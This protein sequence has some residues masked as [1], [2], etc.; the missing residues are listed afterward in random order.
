MTVHNGG[1]FQPGFALN[2]VAP[3]EARDDDVVVDAGGFSVYVDPESAKFLEEP[4][5][6]VVLVEPPRKV[7]EPTV[8]VEEEELELVADESAE[9]EVIKKGKEDGEEPAE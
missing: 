5:R 4:H 6:V 3:D 2:F 1:T 8:E 7:E 9:P